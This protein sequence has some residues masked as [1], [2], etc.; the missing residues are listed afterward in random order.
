MKKSFNKFLEKIDKILQAT[1]KQNIQEY[2]W[3][4]VRN[5]HEKYNFFCLIITGI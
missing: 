3:E 5:F 1:W 4:T 2:I